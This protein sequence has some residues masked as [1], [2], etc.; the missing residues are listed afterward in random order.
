[1]SGEGNGGQ[2]FY[3]F[4]P[5]KEA[6]RP[7]EMCLNKNPVFCVKHTTTEPAK[8]YGNKRTVIKYCTLCN[9]H[10]QWSSESEKCQDTLPKI[11]LGFFCK[12]NALLF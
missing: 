9:V 1:M 7:N 11:R 4:P 12:K 10:V 6:Y 5:V 3:I 8:G 2:T